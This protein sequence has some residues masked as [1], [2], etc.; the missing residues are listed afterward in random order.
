MVRSQ[1]ISLGTRTDG[2]PKMTHS[3]PEIDHQS[4]VSSKQVVKDSLY[5]SKRIAIVR[6]QGEHPGERKVRC[7]RDS[8]G[9]RGGVNQSV[10]DGFIWDM[11][12]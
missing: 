7:R 9:V 1:T 4:R 3:H 5:G 2:R 11:S 8:V 10:R 6:E 12:L